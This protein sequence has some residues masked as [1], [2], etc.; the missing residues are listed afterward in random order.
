MKKSFAFLTLLLMAPIPVLAQ[1]GS[2]AEAQRAA[3]A[4]RAA[5]LEVEARTPKLA[6]T[7]EILPLRIPGHTL[8]ETEGVAKNKAGHLFVYSR[9]GWSGSSRGGNAAR[10]FEFGPDL[11]YI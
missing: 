11:K 4:A 8:G 3:Q 2:Q 6:V 7:E 10:L 5:Q 1:G 9:T